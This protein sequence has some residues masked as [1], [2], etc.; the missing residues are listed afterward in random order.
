MKISRKAWN[1]YISKLA[2]CN[3][4]AADTML[5]YMKAHGIE[6]VEALIN[7]GYAVATK[8]GEAS[9]AIAAE[10]YDATAA[11]AGASVPAAVPAETATYGEV[12]AAVKKSAEYSNQSTIANTVARLVKQ[13]GADTTMQNAVRDNA[14][15]AWIPSGDTCAFCIA[16]ASRGWQYAS[17]RVMKGDH[18]QHIHAN[19]DCTFAVRFDEKS[20]YESYNPDKYAEIYYSAEGSSSTDKINSIRRE[21]YKTNGDTIREQKRIAY[22]K[23]KEK[24]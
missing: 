14:Q 21:L 20:S 6:D 3:K 4:G 18:A 11:L 23:R 2:K 10:M 1:D 24:G 15:W 7:Y 16:L 19:C 22:A 9:A 17:K 8:Y 12:T 13:A 5:A